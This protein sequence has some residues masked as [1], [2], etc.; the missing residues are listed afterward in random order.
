MRKWRDM[1]ASMLR[2]TA[3][4]C[5][6]TSRKGSAG[7]DSRREAEAAVALTGY[8]PPAKMAASAKESPRVKTCTTL[9]WPSAV[10]R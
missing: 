2:A 4:S 9:S 8:W 3:G 1:A 5:S 6:I 7:I 10:A